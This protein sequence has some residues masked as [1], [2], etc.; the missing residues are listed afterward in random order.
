MSRLMVFALVVIVAAPMVLASERQK[1]TEDLRRAL[2]ERYRP[3]RIE[4]S[5]VTRLGQV[6]RMGKLLVLAADAVPAKPFRVIQADRQSP[7]V[8][9]MDF[10][11]VD[12]DPDGRI[13]AERGPLT[14]R[15]GTRLVVLDVQLVAGEVHLLTHTAE[16]VAGADREPRQYGCTE[17]VFPLDARVAAAGEA[18]P[19]IRQIE[20]WLEWTP[21]ERFCAPGI[22][23]VCFEP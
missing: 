4:M 1:G 11:R 20:R 13:V 17:F 18:A 10:A 14:L 16:P 19:V 9:V 12:I 21:T 6:T 2:E 23:P 5:D 22:Y 3:S 15:Q 8:H 7:R